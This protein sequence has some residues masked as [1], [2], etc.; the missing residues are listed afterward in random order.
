MQAIQGDTSH[1]WTQKTS[2]VL[3]NPKISESLE[4]W[5]GR[6]EPVKSGSNDSVTMMAA[7]S[8][9]TVI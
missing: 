1:V 9:W 3:S 6:K 8:L 4:K 2:L 7:F 5:G